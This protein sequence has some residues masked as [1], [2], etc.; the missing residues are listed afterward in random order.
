MQ[1]SESG[2]CGVQQRRDSAQK[3][4]A[5]PT[6]IATVVAAVIESLV[7]CECSDEVACGGGPTETA[8]HQTQ[9]SHPL[10]PHPHEPFSCVSPTT[11]TASG[12]QASSKLRSPS[13]E[14]S[15][16]VTQ[17]SSSDSFTPGHANTPEPVDGRHACGVVSAAL[18]PSGGSTLEEES[19]RVSPQ[20]C[21]RKQP[22]VCASKGFRPSPYDH[23]K[24]KGSSLASYLQR[25]Q[26]YAHGDDTC[27]VVAMIYF[28]RI[29]TKA[30]VPVTGL[31]VHNILLA[32]L[33]VAAKW[34]CDKPYSNKYY[35]AVGG[36]TNAELKSLEVAA[37]RDM[38]FRLHVSAKEYNMYCT[39]FSALIAESNA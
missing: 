31:N 13:S 12:A 2:A 34:S 30:G 9:H 23:F 10:L 15:R 16:G 8:A 19:S 6:T 7:T 38:R 18:P 20:D 5:N 22:S 11:A 37:L 27:L 39:E 4:E 14:D 35:A 33:V 3:A 1:H 36:V 28:D 26:Q 25:W 29:C 24:M 21:M 17:S 32:C